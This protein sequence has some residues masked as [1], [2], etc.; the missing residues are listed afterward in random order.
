M[1]SDVDWLAAFAGCPALREAPLVS[2]GSNAT[3]VNNHA[4]AVT[5]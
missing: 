2:A 3:P 4:N 5:Q 1:Q